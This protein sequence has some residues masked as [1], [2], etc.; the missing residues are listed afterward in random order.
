M[1]D[2]IKWWLPRTQGMSQFEHL[3]GV[4]KN[5]DQDAYTTIDAATGEVKVLFRGHLRNICVTEY[6]SGVSMC[7]SLNKYANDGANL[8]NMSLDETRATL[9]E[10]QDSCHIDLRNAHV[11][12]LEFG[13]NLLMKSDVGRYLK[14]LGDMPRRIRK[15]V[16][17][18]T[19]YY[20]RR[21]RERDTFTLYDKIRDA[22]KKKMVMPSELDGKNLLRVE[23]RYS[24]GIA[25][26][27]KEH[28]VTGDT[29]TQRFFIDKLINNMCSMYDSIQKKNRVNIK[30]IE[31]DKKESEY[32]KLFVA[33]MATVAGDRFS[34]DDYMDELKAQRVFKNKTQYTRLRNKLIAYTTNVPLCEG[35]PLKEEL[36]AKF[37]EIKDMVKIQT[38]I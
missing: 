32:L 21:G 34:I 4:I 28:E 17:D 27:L 25:A 3:K 35:D 14:L 12:A 29:L 9:V 5:D 11:S 23:L 18:E 36:D 2:K 38:L 30:N 13:F 7:G 10:L 8:T 1:Y 26:L 24:N 33:V 6:L 37:E 20:V 16:N 31:P 15:S 19:L 22:K